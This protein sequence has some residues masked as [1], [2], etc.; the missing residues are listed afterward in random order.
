VAS[1]EG[2]S[3]DPQVRSE[4]RLRRLEGEHISELR[5]LTTSQVIEKHDARVDEA[6]S[7]NNHGVRSWWLQRAQ[8]YADELDRREAVR[9]GERM[10]ALTKSLN[11]LTW[12]ITIATF[13]G[14]GLTTWAML[15]GA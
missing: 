1:E 4:R 3:G 11:R 7:S 14:V 9:Q 2:L 10:E 15:S 6:R 8:F 13:I 12:A 5:A